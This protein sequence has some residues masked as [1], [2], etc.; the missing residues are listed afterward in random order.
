M[1]DIKVRSLDDVEQKSKAQVEEEL[2]Q[3]HEDQFEDSE[4]TQVETTETVTVPEET[5]EAKEEAPSFDDKDVLSHINERY[6]K[7]IN[8]LDELFEARETTPE[9]PEDVAAYFKYKQETGRT[10]EEFVK[11]NRDFSNVDQ[12]ELLANYYK[13][14]DEYLDNDDVE[15]MLEDFQYDEDIDEERDI[16]KKKLAKKKAVAEARKFFEDQKEQYKIPLESRQESIDPEVSKELEEFKKQRKEAKEYEESVA[17]NR[18]I[19][20]KQLD[21]VFDSKFKGFEF[22]IDDQ[23]LSYNPSS[24][25]ELKSKNVDVTGWVKSYLGENGLLKDYEGFHRALAIAN[26]PDKF[27]R[28]FYEKGK[29]DAVT[30]D[31]KRTKNVNLSVNKSP[32]VSQKGGMQ[33]KTVTSPSDGNR[34]RIRKRK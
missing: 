24:V 21:E 1:A 23:V 19:Y 27:A 30:T 15:A 9:L 28:Y 33:I 3:K 7:T 2:L 32:E 5:T 17:K 18:E 34:L 6:G 25:D 26:Y 14:K 22:K 16:K 11:L 8:S 4:T 29:S 20:L 31:A 13:T 12:D 10:I